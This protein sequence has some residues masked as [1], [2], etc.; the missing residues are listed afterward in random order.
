MLQRI[1]QPLY[2]AFGLILM[3]GIAFLML[4]IVAHFLTSDDYG[5]L[6]LWLSI[7]NFA[8]IIIGFGL[9]EG[10]YKLAQPDNKAAFAELLATAAS[11]QILL[12]AILL[13]FALPLLFWLPAD[14]RLQ[15][16]LATITL[17]SSA[18]INVPLSWLRLIDSA[19]QFFYF[20]A[21]KA[22]AQAGL[23]ALFLWLG[24]GVTGV[25]LSAA[26]SATGLA[27]VLTL[28]QFT[29]TGWHWHP[30]VAQQLLRYGAPL[31]VSGILLFISAGAERWILAAQVNLAALAQYAIALQFAMMAAFLT[32]PFTLWWFPKRFAILQSEHGL[33]KTARFAQAIAHLSIAFAM[34]IALLAPALIDWLLPARY[35]K[36]ATL[37]PWLALGIALK[38][39]SHL[40][41]TG[42]YH[43]QQP[44]S[45][46]SLNAI[47]AVLALGSFYLASSAAGL[48]GIV[49]AF[50]GI[51]GFRALLFTLVSQRLLWLP[52][53]YST[54]FLQLILLSSVVLLSAENFLLAASIGLVQACH[55]AHWFWQAFSIGTDKFLT[56]GAKS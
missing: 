29:Y 5:R 33:A 49:A 47:C 6:D 11:Q 25:L 36:A 43:Q 22:L 27:I 54:L 34:L 23:T 24:W 17:F 14:L 55:L 28:K 26:I 56:L 44:T 53:Q 41:N 19:K 7:I 13:V 39:I 12:A 10:L 16:L 38:Q 42:C 4:P 31:V 30:A 3:K 46:L 15:A 37:I 50:I 9:L 21:T 35:Q 45:V 18:F 1:K 52:Y 2:Y 40:F 32:E 20:T 51:Y 48:W 8:S